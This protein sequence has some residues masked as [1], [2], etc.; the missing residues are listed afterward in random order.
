VAKLVAFHQTMQAHLI[1]SEETGFLT[2]GGRY[3]PNP[4]TYNLG[5][6]HFLQNFMG[7]MYELL[8]LA[9]R[10]SLMIPSEEQWQDPQFGGWFVKLNDGPKGRPR[11]RVQIGRVLR[12]LFLTDWGGRQFMFE[13]FN[14]TPLH[15][16]LALTMAREEMSASGAYGKYASKVCGI[17]FAGADMT[18]YASTADY[19]K[20][21]DK[22]KIPGAAPALV[23]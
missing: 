18:A 21:Q 23:R 1:A 3:K 6:A 10:S 7:V 22:G 5:R 16:I 15:T 2:P 19:A 9:G 17:E 11:D 12:D 14:G 4:L 13:N 8:D 20:A